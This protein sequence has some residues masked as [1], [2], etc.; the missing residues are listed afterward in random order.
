MT[1]SKT[2]SIGAAL[3]VAAN[4]CFAQISIPSG[5]KV[6]CRLEQTISSATAEEGQSVTLS[7]TDG[8]RVNDVVVI[9]QGS[10]VVGTIVQATAKRRMGRTGK[11]DFSVDKVRAADGE[12]VPLRYTINKK[13]GGSHGVRTGII[14][15]GIAVAFWPAAP[16]VLLMKGKDVTINRGMVIDVFTDQ[17]HTLRLASGPATF[18]PRVQTLAYSDI[19]PV[20][21][22]HVAQPVSVQAALSTTS[23]SVTSDIPGAEIE[24]DGAYSG[25]TPSTFSL[26]AGSHRITVKRGAQVWERIV[27]VQGGGSIN[28]NALLSTK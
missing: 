1:N 10:S 16:L 28:V 23:V 6:S 9:P 2:I 21:Q 8:V 27:Q 26:T 18:A 19:G 12:Y 4:T 17:E 3:V 20:S 15:A 25:S 7:V 5:T 13:E 24:I 22:P 11:L 14:T